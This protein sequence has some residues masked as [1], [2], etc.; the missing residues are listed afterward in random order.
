MEIDFRHNGSSVSLVNK[1]YA[2]CHFNEEQGDIFIRCI[3]LLSF[4]IK[5]ENVDETS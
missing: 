2:Y 3:I 1:Y 5:F 4:V